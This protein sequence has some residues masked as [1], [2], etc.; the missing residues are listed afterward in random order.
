MQQELHVSLTSFVFYYP[1]FMSYLWIIGG[2]LHYFIFEEGRRLQDTALP[3]CPKVAIVVP[4]YNEGANVVEVISHLH[5][6]RYPNYVVIA[7]NDGSRDETGPLLDSLV[8]HHP[9]L[10]VLHQHRNEG[11]AIG[12]T[13]AAQLTDAE[14]L[15]C[16]DGDSLPDPD[17]ITFM[18]TH[19]LADD[20]VGA[21]TGNPRIRNRSTLLGRMQVGEFSSIIG[22]IKR[23]QQLY[24]R[25]MTVSGVMAMFRRSALENVGYWSADMMTEDIDISW[26]LQLSGWRLR[27]EPR[28]LTWILMPETIKGLYRQRLRWAK[29]GLQ[30]AMKYAPRLMHPRHILMWPIFFEFWLS[31]V[32]AY[33]L[34]LLIVLA[35]VGMFFTLPEGWRYDV[36]PRWHGTLLFLTCLAQLLAGIVIDRKYDYR[37]LRYYLDTVWYPVAFWMLGMITTVIA[38]PQVLFRRARSRAR[39]VS[40]DRGMKV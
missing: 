38:L 36:V 40:P 26:K 10:L 1:F 33:S 19:L 6:M 27:Y 14:F 31:V 17:A 15:L 25:L 16:I 3:R 21:V 23:T 29:G 7:V 8:D 24:G 37:I 34:L 28:A 32:W 20:K 2:L 22:L 30:T 9:E 35:L 5:T 4:C 39:W 11:K 13:T 18:L 12:L